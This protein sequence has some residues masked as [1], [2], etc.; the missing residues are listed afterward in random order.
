MNRRLTRWVLAALMVYP[1]LVLTQ[2]AVQAATPQPAKT[3]VV[4]PGRQ[5]R[6]P[7]KRL[8]RQG[9]VLPSSRRQAAR[10]RAMSARESI[11]T[12]ASLMPKRKNASN[13]LRP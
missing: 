11:R 3:A 2:G 1:A 10:F 7:E 12:M 9:R 8:S 5:R 4:H 6:L 13:R